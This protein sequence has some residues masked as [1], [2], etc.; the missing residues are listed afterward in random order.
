M[1]IQNTPPAIGAGAKSVCGSARATLVRPEAAQGAD[2]T[3]PEERTSITA[4]LLEAKTSPTA[5]LL[6]EKN[7]LKMA[8]AEARIWP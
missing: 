4:T 8:Q 6:K 3:L 1:I 7:L 5:K 2:V